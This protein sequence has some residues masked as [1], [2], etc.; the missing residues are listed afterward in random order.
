MDNLSIRFPI[1]IIMKAESEI[2]MTAI[3]KSQDFR[4]KTLPQP[5]PVTFFSVLLNTHL[6][7]QRQ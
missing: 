2:M 7:L 4:R 3:F 1:S 5:I 6:A